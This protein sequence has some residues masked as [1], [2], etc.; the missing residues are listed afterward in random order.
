MFLKKS[1]DD[2][3]LSKALTRKRFN[4]FMACPQNISTILQYNYK[5]RS[6][7]TLESAS[8]LKLAV[9]SYDATAKDENQRLADAEIS[10]SLSL[11]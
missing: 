4:Y 2:C 6:L 1:A 3:L 10:S 8:R 9:F 5:I 11:L 7:L